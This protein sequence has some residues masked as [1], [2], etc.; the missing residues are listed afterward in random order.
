MP[1]LTRMSKIQKT[2]L[3]THLENNKF[4][5][6]SNKLKPS[7]LEKFANGWKKFASELIKL[8]GAQK[9]VI[10]WKDVSS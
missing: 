1:P 10:Q 3:V 2:F 8:E 7:E 6:Q 9:N 5:L 4:L